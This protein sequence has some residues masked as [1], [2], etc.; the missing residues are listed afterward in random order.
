MSYVIIE[1]PATSWSGGLGDRIVGLVS[2]IILAHMLDKQLL[3]KWDSPSIHGVLDLN[4]FNYYTR[5]PN[6]QHAIQLH[7]IDNRFKF[8]S[9]LGS[10]P[11]H[12]QWRNSNVWLKCN[13]ELGF[14][15][16]QNP[17]LT[18]KHWPGNNPYEDHMLHCYQNIWTT[19]LKPIGLSEITGSFPLSHPYLSIQLRTGA[20]WQ[21]RSA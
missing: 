14:F 9:L 7:T 8:Q 17:H 6:L 4:P 12:Q 21:P 16:Y 19:W 5:R 3:I 11:I 13:Q 10:Q 18:S 2:A 15:L 20:A 1:Y